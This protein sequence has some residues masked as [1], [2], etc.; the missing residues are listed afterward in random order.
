M[1]DPDVDAGRVATALGA[2]ADGG[3]LYRI[4]AEVIGYYDPGFESFRNP[5]QLPDTGTRLHRAPGEMLEVVIPNV[6]P[7]GFREEGDP[8]PGMAWM[9]RL[10]NR[11]DEKVTIELPVN[12]GGGDPSRYPR[13]RRAAESPTLPAYSSRK[14]SNLPRALRFWYLIPMVSTTVSTR[15]VTIPLSRVRMDTGH[16][17][18]SGSPD[19][20]SVKLS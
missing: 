18:R 11:A 17:P 12:E 10:L 13:P 15:C 16:L 5:R 3:E 19:Q 14:C 4:T 8:D 20:L 2:E 9:G 1:T 7:P 6:T